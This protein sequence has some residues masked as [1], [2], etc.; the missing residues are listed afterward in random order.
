M[1]AKPRHLNREAL[2]RRRRAARLNGREL[3]LPATAAIEAERRRLRAHPMEYDES[4]FPIQQRPLNT[5]ARLRR[6]VTG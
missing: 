2:Y 1:S 6:L 5:A 3:G 4:G